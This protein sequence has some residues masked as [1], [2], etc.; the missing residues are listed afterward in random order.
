[1]GISHIE[2]AVASLL[3]IRSACFMKSAVGLLTG[4]PYHF[5]GVFAFL[6]MTCALLAWFGSAIVHSGG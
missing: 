3:P 6:Q 1:M 5:V 4:D 2:A